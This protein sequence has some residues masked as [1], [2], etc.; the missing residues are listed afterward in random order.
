LPLGFLGAAIVYDYNLSRFLRDEMA[1]G[2]SLAM[3]LGEEKARL[4]C[5]V[6]PALAYGM[7]LVDVAL[8]EYPGST[9]WALATSPYL[10]WKLI[11][12]DG[13]D[14]DACE[15]LTRSTAAVFVLTALLIALGFGLAGVRG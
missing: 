9:V 1:A 15:D 4:V 13:R 10:I 3:D 14:A 8:G 5:S 12:F 11:R 6:L 2:T 7:I